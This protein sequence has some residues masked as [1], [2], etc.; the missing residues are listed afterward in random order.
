M[1]NSKDMPFLE[2]LHIQGN[3]KINYQHSVAE[4]VSDAICHQEGQLS[5]QG[6]LNADTGRFTGRSPKDRY[7]VK[8]PLTAET[9]SWGAIN[10]PFQADH[11]NTL[12]ALVSQH[13]SHREIYVRDAIAGAD[14]RYALTLR[15]ITENA[16][17]NIFAHN[18]FIQPIVADRLTQPEWSILSAPSLQLEDYASYGLNNSNFVI[19]NF[20]AKIVLIA[21][22]GYTGEI[23]KSVFSILNFLLPLQH[24]ILTMHCS[25]NTDK[26]GN[27]ALFFGLSGTG[28]TTLSA[29]QNR[30]L[31]GDD[32]HGWSE[33]SVFNFEGGCYAKCVNLSEEKEPEIFKAVKFGA[34]LENVNFIP[35]TRIP[36]YDDITKTENTRV[37]YPLSFIEGAVE[38][39]QG[40]TPKNIFFLTADASGVLPPISKLSTT[41]AMFHFISGYTSKLAGTEIGVK[42]PQPVFSACFGEAFFP[43]HPGKYAELLREKLSKNP[44]IHVWLVNT[45][46]IA[47]PYGVGRRIKLGY[48]RQLIRQAMSGSLLESEYQQDEVFGLSFPTS[49]GD[50][51]AGVLN[52]RNLWD[53]SQAY[54]QAANKLAKLFLLNMDKY[55]DGL[56]ED[57]LASA[58]EI[59]KL[60]TEPD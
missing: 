37:S 13:L 6:A 44:E 26:E 50:V 16:Y 46:W 54:D 33:D 8:D 57:V 39:G 43:L 29:D 18:L 38:S 48:T 60:N 5:E 11:F 31:I 52:P 25:A 41:Q 21:G 59:K 9:V 47:G 14:S 20:S 30:F 56:S 27:T 36:N 28:K 42:E 53:D 1:G 17:Q 12:Y 2:Y 58:P 32:E 19:I 24:R 23:K 3:T 45:G 4:L 51:P 40:K 49:A 15:V 35:N 34:L 22:T 55:K 7:I 10:Q